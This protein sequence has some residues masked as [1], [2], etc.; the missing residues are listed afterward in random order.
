[1]K[2]NLN[3]LKLLYY[4]MWV[5]KTLFISVLLFLFALSSQAQYSCHTATFVEVKDSCQQ[6]AYNHSGYDDRWFTFTPKTP[7]VGFNVI[8]I[9]TPRWIAPY[10]S[11]HIYTGSC[12]SLVLY[13]TISIIGN[14]IAEE[15]YFNGDND[16]YFR[17]IRNVNAPVFAEYDLCVFSLPEQSC[18]T[19]TFIEVKDSCELKT[20]YHIGGSDRWF[21]FHQDT[22][23]IGMNV[24]WNWQ[25]RLGGVIYDSLFIYIGNCDSLVEFAVYSPV[26]DSLDFNFGGVESVY[27]RFVRFTGQTHYTMFDLCVFELKDITTIPCQTPCGNITCGNINLITNG[28]FDIISNVPYSLNP[29]PSLS[30]DL[31]YVTNDFGQY[32]G[33]YTIT[34]SLGLD[35]FVTAN[36][37]QTNDNTT[38]NQLYVY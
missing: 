29:F 27:L 11:L 12:D 5:G 31:Q 19:A 13:D 7:G 25:L 16:V 30:S 38:T 21:V 18:E 15:L 8:W 32:G 4:V 36:G 24:Q 35:P 10:T 3:L 2:K 14:H 9:L 37:V 28:N 22:M 33:K 20:Y 6:E 34:G 23:N 26:P 1:M 17:F